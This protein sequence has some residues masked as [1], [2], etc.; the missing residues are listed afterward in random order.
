MM[1]EIIERNIKANLVDPVRTENS[2]TT[3]FPSSTFLSNRSLAALELKLGNSLV[4]GLSVHNTLGNWP[5]PSTS[6]YTNS[7]DH[8]S[9]QDEIN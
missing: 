5:L 2:K 1:H 4:G 6:S 3:Q 8:I 7:V 9:L